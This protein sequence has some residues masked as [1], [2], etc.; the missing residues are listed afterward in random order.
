MDSLLRIF[1]QK[2]RDFW[3][4]TA[5]KGQEVCEIRLRVDRPVIIETKRRELFLN[6]R[7]QWQENPCGAYS[8]EEAEIRELIAY[9]CQ[10]SLYAYADEIR[11]GF[12]TVEGGHRIG[13]CGQAVLEN[14]SR[15]R[16]LKN[17]SFVNIRVSHE[18]KGAA[19]KILPQLYRG[20]RFQN[21]LIVSPPGFGKTTLLRDL[22]RQLSDG[23]AYGPGLRVGVVDERSE[24]AGSYRGRPQN[25]LGM[26]TDVLDA[27]PKAKG[28]QMLLRSMS[29]DVVAVDE[30]GK[31]EDFKAVESVVHCGCKL[32]ATAHGNSLEDI[33]RQPFFQKLRE[34]EVFERYIV[35]GKKGHAGS[36]EAIYDG[37]GKPC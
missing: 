10:D 35:L 23:N 7:G 13:L 19:D 9:L 8:V 12:L 24:L 32:F 17:I 27:C 14:E 33:L 34:L 30:L 26:R 20:G 21:T 31:K 6:H 11:Q 29:P 4:E 3:K 37:K 36:I 18:V 22:I 1:P 16:T 25:D 15:L 28:M 2:R 5:E